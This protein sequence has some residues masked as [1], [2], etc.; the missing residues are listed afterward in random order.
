M[1]SNYLSPWRVFDPFESLFGEVERPEISGTPVFSP[2]YVEETEKHYLI[3]MDVPGVAKE[4]I[5]VQMENK[6]LIVEGERKGR[7]SG[8][9]KKIY[10]LPDDAGTEGVEAEHKNGVLAIAIP[11][12]AKAGGKLIPILG[13]EK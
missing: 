5:K 13:S 8:K 12:T 4:D 1:R 11:K 7:V 2:S 6:Q 9:F 3:E 10:H